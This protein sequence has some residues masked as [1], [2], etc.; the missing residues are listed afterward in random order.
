[1]KLSKGHRD[2]NIPSKIYKKGFYNCLKNSWRAHQIYGLV[3]KVDNHIKL[4]SY[5]NNLYPQI[6][7]VA[8]SCLQGNTLHMTD[9]PLKVTSLKQEFKDWNYGN[10]GLISDVFNN[11]AKIDVNRIQRFCLEMWFLYLHYWRYGRYFRQGILSGCKAILRIATGS[12]TSFM[13]KVTCV[14]F[15]FIFIGIGI[16]RTYLYNSILAKYDK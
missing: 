10:D 6:Y 8:S 7:F 14:P 12:N 15:C 9:Y 5:I 1:M 16:V 2:I 4:S 13:T 3:F 11:Y